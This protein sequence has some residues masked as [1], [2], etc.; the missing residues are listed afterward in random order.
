MSAAASERDR[1][2]VWLCITALCVGGAEQ[3]LVDLANALDTDRYDVTVWTIFET[4][5][6]KADLKSDVTVRSL[7]A[8]GVVENGSVAAATTPLAYVRAVT[9][10]CYFAAV[11][12]PDIVHSFLLFDN[13]LAR[14][15]GLCSPATVV[16]GVRAV[17]DEPPATRAALDRLT[18]GLSDRIVSNSRAGAQ[19]A[20]ER[21]AAPETVS[22]VHNGRHIPTYRDAS[23]DAVRA[24]LGID[25]SELVV[26]TVG[27][28]LER[29]GH[30]ELVAAWAQV[31]QTHPDARLVFV[32]DGQDR[33]EIEAHARELGCADSI[34]FLGTRRDVPQLLAAMDVFAF[35]SHF[36]GLP[37]AVIEAMAAGRPIVATPVDGTAELLDS[38]HTGLFV[39]PDAPD[40]LA[41]ALT[42]LL[43]TPRLR[44][45]LGAAAQRRAGED[46]AIDSMVSEFE[47]LY[48]DI[49]PAEPK[50][51]AA[52][53]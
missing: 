51:R 36:E 10:F 52:V 35:P 5:P 26:G 34:D 45:S 28:L 40:E 46:F 15:A 16:T 4:G 23:A 25:D 50:P 2:S 30:F 18:I 17:P 19:L 11:E 47:A 49:E 22:V 31:E 48:R 14:L 27:R 12:R 44:E 42:R 53:S 1:V 38:Y 32:G 21:G 6:L 7:T 8:R 29:K 3:T 39:S 43:D 24:E 13:L 37:G 20:V 33:A 41:W 9:A